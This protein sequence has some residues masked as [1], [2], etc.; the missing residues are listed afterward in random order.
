[1]GLMQFKNDLWF[2]EMQSHSTQAQIRWQI[3]KQ[4][5][6]ERIGNRKSWN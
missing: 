6:D 5:K 1:M 3:D 2:G 4:N